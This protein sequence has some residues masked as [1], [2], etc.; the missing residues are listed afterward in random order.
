MIRLLIVGDYMKN[1]VVIIISSMLVICLCGLI[2]IAINKNKDLLGNVKKVHNINFSVTKITKK[3]E[4]YYVRVKL[5]MKKKTDVNS[6]T[7][8]LKDKNNKSLA[9]LRSEIKDLK[10]NEEK[11]IKLETYSN[12]KGAYEAIYTVYKE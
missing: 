9:V 4:K 12:L 8:E 2:F 6:F 3:E 11:E 1:K 10:V 5:V 7:I